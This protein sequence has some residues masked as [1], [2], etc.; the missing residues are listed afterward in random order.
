M[1]P[2]Q[3]PPT[4]PILVIAT[5]LVAGCVADSG[6]EPASA[7]E[8]DAWVDLF[9]GEDLTGWVPKIRGEPL[10]E[11]ARGTFRVEDG[12]LS[13][14][15]DQYDAAV[16]FDDT[17]GHLFYVDPLDGYELLV[18]YR[19]VG[20]QFAGGPGWARS[21]SGVMFHAQAPETMGVD[22]DF[23]I[24]LEAQFLGGAADEVRPTA[25]LCT[26]GTHVD[27]SGEQV[28]QHCVNAS[29]PTIAD[30]TWVSVTIMA[31]PDGAVRHVIDGQTVIEYQRPVVGGGEVSE[32]TAGAPPEGTA[33]LGGYVALQSE[34]HPIQFR[35]VA[36]RPLPSPG[37]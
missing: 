27:M 28:T 11:D 12:L 19:F 13:V 18:E 9:N 30:S 32:R 1:N 17:F 6:D 10:G 3:R 16:G 36:I 20:R 14:S 31:Y 5:A 4:I 15:Y 23:P 37:R 25:N 35:R 33:L 24:S 2:L 34:S 8:S 26:P 7:P 29:A 22:Q 21:N